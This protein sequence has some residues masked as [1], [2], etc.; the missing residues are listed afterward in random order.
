MDT[1]LFK[2]Q[3]LE[4]N[5]EINLQCDD[6]LTNHHN[7]QLGVDLFF[8]HHLSLKYFPITNDDEVFSNLHNFSMPRCLKHLGKPLSGSSPDV[9]SNN[10]RISNASRT[11]NQSLDYNRKE[12]VTSREPIKILLLGTAESGKT[13][14]IKQMRI[15]HVNG[16]TDK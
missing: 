14:I 7:F 13:T 4:I 3:R 11:R 2:I 16:Y 1:Y 15:L 5:V 6:Y 9:E 12:T 8:H 10:K